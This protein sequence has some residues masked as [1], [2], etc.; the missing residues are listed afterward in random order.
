MRENPRQ[1]SRLTVMTQ[2]KNTQCAC[3]PSCGSSDPRDLTA[4]PGRVGES[5][6]E[7]LGNKGAS[8]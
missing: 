8:E 5:S 2:C 4:D 6:H 7:D 3:V 1:T